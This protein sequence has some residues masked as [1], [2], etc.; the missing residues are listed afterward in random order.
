MGEQQSLDRRHLA[1]VVPR[2]GP[3]IGGGIEALA[4]MYAQR[5][6]ERLDVTVLTTC[7]YDYMTWEDH[8]P[9]GEST[10]GAVRVCRF[11]VPRPRD[12][13]AFNRLSE[14]VLPVGA[15]PSAALQDEWMEA[16][17]PVSPGLLDHL[18][19]HADNYD[20]VLFMPYLYAT[21]AQGIGLVG[22]RAVLQ[23]AVHDEAPLALRLF[24]DVV[25]RARSVMFNTPEERARFVDRFGWGDDG[26]VAGAGVDPAPPSDGTRGRRSL[27]V[28]GDY[29]VCVGRVDPSKG[30]LDLIEVHDRLRR[31][32]PGAPDLV[33]LGG[34]AVDLPQHP[35][36]HAPGYVDEQVKHDVI[37]GSLALVCPSPH[38]SL[39]LVLLEAWSHGR[40]T[41]VAAGTDVLV[42]QTRRAQAGLWYADA[43]EY[44]EAIDLLRRN[45]SIAWALGH[46]GR[47]F[48]ATLGWETVLDR[49]ESA[50]WNRREPRSAGIL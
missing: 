35:W 8:Y 15:S 38:E 20:A 18:R 5:L 2:Y 14:R 48:V 43:E 40:P 39:S 34:H 22:D 23:P 26:V 21:T 28:A 12:V 36:L 13:R 37:A 45:P 30:T 19:V 1:I 9:P 4:R 47:R 44:I 6:A 11:S 42:G 49:V 31:S 3:E 33:L 25:S 17:G 50:L 41:V 7:A 32:I 16:Q 10:D 29:V 24:D 46:A 27:G